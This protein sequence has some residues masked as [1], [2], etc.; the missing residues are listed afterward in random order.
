M[1]KIIFADMDKTI[2]RN[3][4]N[5]VYRISDED[6]EA[7]NKMKEDGIHFII[8]TGRFGLSIKND[9][10][11]YGIWCDRVTS[12]GSAITIDDTVH[13]L[14]EVDPFIFERCFERI[15]ERF[16]VFYSNFVIR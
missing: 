14:G 8:T 6:V 9:M 10:K 7:I 1:I 5:G 2:V 3:D 12:S 11:K 16:P 15:N 13:L 4:E